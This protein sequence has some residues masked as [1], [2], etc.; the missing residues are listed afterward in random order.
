MEANLNVS[1][2]L[3]LPCRK[4]KAEV[5]SIRFRKNS[6]KEKYLNA[7]SQRQ[8]SKVRSQSHMCGKEGSCKYICI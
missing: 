2:L 8:A 5:Y 3:R 6:K 4:V 1:V 7:I